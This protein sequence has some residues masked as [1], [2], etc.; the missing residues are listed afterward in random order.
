MSRFILHNRY[1]SR[2][3]RESS[4]TSSEPILAKFCTSRDVRDAITS[5]HSGV[6]KLRGYGYTECRNLE[7]AIEIAGHTYNSV[8]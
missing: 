8:T 5:T 6:Y 1:I 4:E 3:S 7:F 2:I